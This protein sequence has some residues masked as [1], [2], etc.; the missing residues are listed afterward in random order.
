M[1]PKLKIRTLKPTVLVCYCLIFKIACKARY[2]RLVQTT[3]AGASEPAVHMSALAHW[4]L[5]SADQLALPPLAPCGSAAR[6]P[7][8]ESGYT[9]SDRVSAIDSQI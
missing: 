7:G 4:N 2:A 3:T 9:R 5:Q 6:K 1:W 8:T